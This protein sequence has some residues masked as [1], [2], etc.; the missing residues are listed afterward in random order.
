MNFILKSFLFL[1]VLFY[2]RANCQSNSCDSL[3]KSYPGFDQLIGEIVSHKD[4]YGTT[5][6]VS[7]CTNSFPGCG[8]CNGSS[9]SGYCEYFEEGFSACIGVF[10]DA[11]P[12][13][14]GSGIKIVYNKDII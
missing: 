13:T 9:D 2:E 14:I 3:K 4:E 6:K 7:I 8:K 10:T 11:Q 5:F 12:I 1:F